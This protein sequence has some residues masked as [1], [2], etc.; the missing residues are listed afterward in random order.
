M[1]IEQM[2]IAVPA[3]KKQQ[4]GSA[5]ASFV[6]PTEVQPGCISCSLSQ[7]WANPEELRLESRWANEDDLI[8]HLKSDS[9]KQLLLLMELSTSPP[10]IEFFDVVKSQGLDL[11]QSVRST[12]V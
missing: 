8:R 5:L 1:I 7:N 3:D 4:L 9:Y 6:G 10:Q 2:S 12:P 11:V